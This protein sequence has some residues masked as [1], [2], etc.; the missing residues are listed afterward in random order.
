MKAPDFLLEMSKQLKEQDNRCTA[1]PIF[2]VAY[3]KWLTCA[4]GRGDKEIYL[5]NNNCE[6]TECDNE[7]EVLTYFHDNH[8]DWINSIKVQKYE[9][10][11]LSDDYDSFEQY[12][13]SDD[14]NLEL[15]S[16]NYDY[17]DNVEIEKICMQKQMTV[18][19]SHLT[20]EGAKQFIA[21]KQHDYSKLYIYAYSMYH[22]SQ[23]KELRAWIISLTDDLNNKEDKQ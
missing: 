10:D 7:S 1:D 20:E 16:S 21:R 11:C 8:C 15:D 6:Y 19:N 12:V 18:V 23:M 5:I 9:D 14:F 13:E 22:C 17:P 3:D 4:D 2:M